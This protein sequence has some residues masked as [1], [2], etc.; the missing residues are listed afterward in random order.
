MGLVLVGALLGLSGAFLIIGGRVGKL[1]FD[2]S[3]AAGYL[4][5]ALCAIIWSSYSIM[6]RRLAS[7]PSDAVT[8]FCA[9]S[10]LL[11]LVAH[12]LL[13]QTT[14]P[15]TTLQWLAVIGLGLGP[16][17]L[18]FYAWDYGVKKGNIQVLGAASYAAPV[19]STFALI[20]AGIAAFNWT[21]AAATLLVTLG[22][23]IAAKDMIGLGKPR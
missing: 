1:D 23:L 4:S 22:A 20:G 19:L 5:A 12:L 2:P 14:W 18:A 7:V 10:C 15:D 6:S 13:E 3:Y 16:V 8:G 11:A 21:I 9:I 17:G